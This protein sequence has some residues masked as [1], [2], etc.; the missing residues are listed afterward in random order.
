MTIFELRAR[1]QCPNTSLRLFR[2]IERQF[3]SGSNSQRDRGQFQDGANEFASFGTH[4]DR[5]TSRTRTRVIYS[6]IHF[7]CGHFQRYDCWKR[8]QDVCA[9][10]HAG[11]LLSNT[12]L[13]T[14]IQL[15]TDF[16]G[17]RSPT[18]PRLTVSKSRDIRKRGL[19]VDVSGTQIFPSI[20][21]VQHL[22]EFSLAKA[23]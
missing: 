13:N 9:H 17:I 1:H 22:T 18:P 15:K 5:S 20:V 4:T 16:E 8:E 6:G 21:I 14:A 10:A 11:A 19:D 2:A 12:Q 23:T 7:G 3:G